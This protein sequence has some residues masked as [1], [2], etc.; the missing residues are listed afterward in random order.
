M[1]KVS[2][3]MLVFLFALLLACDGTDESP[4]QSEDAAES[5]PV[6]Q[7]Y[8]GQLQ[9][10][11][12]KVEPATIAQQFY[13]DHGLPQFR[14]SSGTF[15]LVPLRLMAE[16]PG[17]KASGSD[18]PDILRFQKYINT[19]LLVFS[20][21]TIKGLL[22]PPSNVDHTSLQSPIRNQGSR[23]TCVAHASLAALESR[24]DVPDD[25][26][27]QFAYHDFM[28]R[29]SSN[30][31]SDPGVATINAAN[32]LTAQGV[33]EETTWTYTLTRPNCRTKT[34]CTSGA[35]HTIPAAATAATKYWITAA[36][37]IRD[38]GLAGSSIKN[39]AYLE[40]LLAAGSD[41]VWGTYVAWDD[42]KNKGILDVV[43]D[44]ATGKPAASRGGHAMVIV[45]YDRAQKYFIVKN[46]WRTRWGHSGYGH[47]SYDYIRTYSK[48]GYVV[49]S[50][51][52]KP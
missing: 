17:I 49:R 34:T 13:I 11:K 20:P 28:G 24:S 38:T 36:D 1:R 46:S 32:Y 2:Q 16:Q 12:E 52:A 44:S 50:V 47:F 26:S 43:I 21:E 33:P 27:E 19:R 10:T 15:V 7:D 41:I 31:C 45:G 18:R 9:Q 42:S 29:V 25:L 3:F 5:V 30:C 8:L 35:A 39:P 4:E 23:G 40:A 14:A 48:Y 22:V 6:E 51:Q 37:R